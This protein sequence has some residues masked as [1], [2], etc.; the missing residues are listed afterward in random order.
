MMGIQHEHVVRRDLAFLLP[1][2]PVLFD[3]VFVDMS[4]NRRKTPITAA[5]S[6]YRQQAVSKPPLECSIC[7]IS[8]EEFPPVAIIL[9]VLLWPM[10]VL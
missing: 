10:L 6:A 5:S 3:D 4:L 7:G 8:A 1:A 2:F 9:G